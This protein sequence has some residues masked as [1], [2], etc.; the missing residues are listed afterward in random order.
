[1]TE[2]SM[3][4]RQV[5]DRGEVFL[6]HLAHFVPSLDGAAAALEKLGFRLTPFAAQR[7][8]PSHGTEPSGMATRCALLREVIL[9]FLTPGTPR[10]M[11]WHVP[12]RRCRTVRLTLAAPT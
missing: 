10:V 5:P 3:I 12:T 9:D 8:R 4:A 11:A 7:N 2:P 1:M 6:D